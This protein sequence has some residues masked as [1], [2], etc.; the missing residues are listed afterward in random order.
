LNSH[1]V[2]AFYAIQLAAI[3][4]AT[5]HFLCHICVP[6]R[7]HTIS[8]KCGDNWSNGK[9]IETLFSKVKMAA[10][11]ML[12]FGYLAFSTPCLYIM[13]QSRNIHTKFSID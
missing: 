2:T 3:C 5:M 4:N 12:N 1:E 8:T 11:T 10:I 13:Y 6:N 7:G 9:Q